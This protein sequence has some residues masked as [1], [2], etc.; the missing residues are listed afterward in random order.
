VP[1]QYCLLVIE[2]EANAIAGGREREIE[3]KEREEKKSVLHA[4]YLRHAA[5]S[6]RLRSRLTSLYGSGL[7]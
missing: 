4:D 3:G 1:Q 7:L 6:Q 5:H 2:Q